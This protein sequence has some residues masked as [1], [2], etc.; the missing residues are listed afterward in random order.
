MFKS[1][2]D[3]S[4]TVRFSF[5]NINFNRFKMLIIA[6][7]MKNCFILGLSKSIGLKIF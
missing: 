6:I 4:K 3:Y 7:K 2:K 1:K 5:G